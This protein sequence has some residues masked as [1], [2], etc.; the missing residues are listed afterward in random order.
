MSKSSVLG[1]FRDPDSAAAGLENLQR[2]GL[3]DNEY[4]V[5]TGTPYPEGTFGEQPVRHHLYVFPFI[6]ALSGLTVA[7]LL[8]VATQVANPMV[9]GGKPILAIPPMVIVAFEGTM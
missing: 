6:G 7:I 8:T 5:L 3:V 1:L 2:A 9:T 4:E